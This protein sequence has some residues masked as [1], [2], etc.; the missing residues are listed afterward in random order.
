MNIEA[1]LIGTAIGDAFG[2]GIEFQ[3]RD[4][5]L[6]NVNF[7]EF[8]NARNKIQVESDKLV[9]FTENYSSWDYT[10]DTEMTIGVINA[11]LSKEPFSEELLISKWKEEYEEG[12]KKKGFGRNGH[13]SMRW[14]YSREKS[15]EEIKSFQR[16]RHNPGNAPAMRAVPL[17]LIEEKLINKYSAINA[18]ATHPNLNAILSSQCIA[19]AAHFILVLKGDAKNVIDYCLNQIDFNNEYLE[20]LNRVNNIPTDKP[21]TENDFS[22]LCGDQPIKPPYF[23]PGI[24]G[25]PSDSKL[26]AGG[27]L[28]ILKV[29]KTPFD[30]LKNSINFG[31]DVDSLA[32]ITTGILA[33]K[34]GLSSIPKFMQESVEGLEYLKQKSKQLESIVC[35]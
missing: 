31:G 26:T 28:Y 27:V 19:R 11:L 7:N 24:K 13:G 23:L 16:N 17:G 34:M 35:L 32:S 30:A 9:L 8:V 4:W 21:L 33:G 25:M 22:I 15:I 5:I 20:Y 29:S 14:Y 10:D 18:E 12:I 6:E 3:D 2:A 1:L